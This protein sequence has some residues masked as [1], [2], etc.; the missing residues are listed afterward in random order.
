M[1]SR[2]HDQQ[3]PPPRR[4]ENLASVHPRSLSPTETKAT[5]R[6]SRKEIFL[7]Y[8]RKDLQRAKLFVR[9]LEQQGWSVWWDANIPTGRTVTDVIEEAIESA[10]C[11]IVLW[12]K[13]SVK[14]KWVKKEAAEGE[15]RDVLLPVLID[16]VRV[17]FQFRQLQNSRL[18]EWDGELSHPELQKLLAGVTN[19]LDDSDA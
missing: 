3:R 1:S 13:H 14:S 18:V 10:K 17:P 9:I 15:E 8:A 12:S 16:D 7:S 4:A 2:G 11:V 19:L 5:A 6:T